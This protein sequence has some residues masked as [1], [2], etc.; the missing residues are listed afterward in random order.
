MIACRQQMFDLEMTAT[1][2]GAIANGQKSG[3]SAFYNSD[4]HYD[5]LVCKNDD[6]YTVDL[7]KRVADIDVTV[8]SHKIDYQ[9]AISLMIRADLEWY[10]FLYKKDGKLIELGKGKTS[11]LATE[12]TNPMTFTGTFLG[13]FTE[14][15]NISVTSVSVK[16]L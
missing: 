11:L 9:G 5:I 15:G 13:V 4:F 2:E 16:E 1:L 3:I 6:G 14:G 12:V 8:A 7:R 10:T